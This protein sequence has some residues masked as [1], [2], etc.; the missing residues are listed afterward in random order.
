MIANIK[1]KFNWIYSSHYKMER[2][3][4]MFISI[5]LCMVLVVVSIFVRK[6]KND[7]LLLG[8]QVVY[9]NTFTTSLSG[10]TGSVYDV[11]VSDDKTKCF[12][13]LKWE[14]ISKVVTDA[15]KYELFI[16]GSDINGNK[17]ELLSKPAVGIYMFGSTGYMGIYLSDINGFP[18]Q[19]LDIVVRCNS[20]VGSVVENVATYDDAS[21]T[22]YDQFRLYINPGGSNYKTGY[23][24]N[25]NRLGVFDIFE[26]MIVRDK[27]ATIKETL[28]ND[29]VQMQTLLNEMKEYKFRLE[30]SNIVVPDSPYSIRSDSITTD[31]KGNLQLN[32]DYVMNG[33]YSFDWRNGSVMEGYLSSIDMPEGMTADN[34]LYYQNEQLA[35]N[36]FSLDD[37]NWVYSDGRMVALNIAD[38]T[39]S[40]DQIRSNVNSLTTAWTKYYNLKLK[41]QTADMSE[42]VVLEII[43]N[44][45]AKNYTINADTSNVTLW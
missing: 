27:E 16:T 4:I 34:Y 15:S 3:G 5:F 9:T 33:G 20:M 29:L 19:I 18:L 24:L 35:K 25:D 38:P 10:V 45:V 7:V 40:I 43:C 13:M 41:Y 30:Q 8:E 26:E 12:I 23:F 6:S 32:T 1:A 36:D 2:F 42:L 14:D 44:N 37:L 28:N 17:L 21:F 11:V 39:G 22:K 31:D